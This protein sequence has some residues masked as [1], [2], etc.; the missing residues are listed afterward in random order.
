MAN[1]RSSLDTGLLYPIYLYISGI[2]ST[3]GSLIYSTYH[4]NYSS[5]C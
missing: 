1:D 3:I 2:N 4:L 5:H